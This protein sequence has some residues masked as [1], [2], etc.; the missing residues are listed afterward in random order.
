MLMNSPTPRKFMLTL[1]HAYTAYSLPTPIGTC[2]D[3]SIFIGIIYSMAMIHNST[4]T[5]ACAILSTAWSGV[6]RPEWH[7]NFSRGVRGVRRLGFKFSLGFIY[8]SCR[9]RTG[10]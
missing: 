1:M 7:G 2:R 5:F 9:I 10:A 6:R 4:V 8:F 3:F